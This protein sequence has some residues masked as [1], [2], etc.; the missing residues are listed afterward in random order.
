MATNNLNENSKGNSKPVN[1]NEEE[2]NPDEL[3]TFPKQQKT[4]NPDLEEER[5]SHLVNTKKSP[6]RDGQR[7]TRTG[8]NPDQ[9]GFM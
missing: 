7:I 2:L 6:A 8:P 4:E 1:P 3:A 5:Q 9:D